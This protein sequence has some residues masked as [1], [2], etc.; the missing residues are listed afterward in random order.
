MA[1]VE[2]RHSAAMALP[3][4]LLIRRIVVFLVIEPV[5][6]STG[7]CELLMTPSKSYANNIFIRLRV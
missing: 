7:L 4:A 6:L 3:T 2:T 5:V 1:S